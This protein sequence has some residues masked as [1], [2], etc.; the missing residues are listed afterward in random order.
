MQY[1]E[2]LDLLGKGFT[3]AQITDLANAPAPAPEPAPVPAPAPTPEPAPE[4]APA[5]APAPD[6]AP[7]WAVALNDSITKMTM[8]VQAQGI[9]NSIQP[10][11]QVET[12]DDIM[13]QMIS[14]P[15][16]MKKGE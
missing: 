6:Q 1:S 2:I 15:V 14:P 8:A 16:P 10:P 9:M 4:P 12:V 5:P 7:A 11:K 13:A 3:P